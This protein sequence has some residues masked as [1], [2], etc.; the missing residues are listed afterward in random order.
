MIFISNM[1]KDEWDSAILTRTFRQ[2]MDFSDDEMLDFIDKIKGT[3]AAPGLTDDMKQEVMAYIRERHESG[4]L[5]SPVN[6][7][8]VQQAFDLRLTANWKTMIDDL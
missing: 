6:F 4:S 7:R 5:N 2:Y 3:I 8:L 1:G